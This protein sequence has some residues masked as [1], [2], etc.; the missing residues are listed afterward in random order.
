MEHERTARNDDETRR[1][2]QATA[3]TATPRS[4]D[5]S[6]PA[7]G[8]ISPT[9]PLGGAE[10]ITGGLSSGGSLGGGAM[11]GPLG[12]GPDPQRSVLDE[13]EAGAGSGAA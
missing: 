8:R 6:H 13:P 1:Q 12:S 7:E 5:E 4:A 2:E 9:G 11:A 3:E 10:S